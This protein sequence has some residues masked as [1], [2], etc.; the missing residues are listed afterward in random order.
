MNFSYWL[1][2][3]PLSFG[4]FGAPVMADPW[5]DLPLS[6]ASGRDSRVRTVPYS[7]DTVYLLHGFVGYDIEIEFSPDEALTGVGGGDLDGVV[8]GSHA[9][10]FTIK[11]RALDVRTNLLVLTNKHRYLFDYV[12][13]SSRPD[14][15]ADDVVYLLRFAY[16]DQDK[17]VP[18]MRPEDQIGLDLARAEHRAR[19]F[20]YWY[21]GNPSIKPV[22]ASDDGVHTRLKFPPRAE[23]PAVFVRNDD[24]SESLLNFSIDDGDVVIHRVARR[25]ILRRGQL[26]GCVVNK[27]FDGG[28]DRLESGTVS[29][30]VRRETQV[31]HP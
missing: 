8:Y 29:P 12:V 7:A 25:L 1:V 28:G 24:G 17:T 20:D 27:D 23:L 18:V 22:A 15:R 2:F 14:M 3:A 30:N 19:N 13:I 4:F 10:Y 5:P 9:N 26:T 11:P 31:P 21:C 16:P 6:A